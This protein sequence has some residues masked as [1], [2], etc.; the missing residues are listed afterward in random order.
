[1]AG[2]RTGIVTIPVVVHVVYNT[3]EQNISDLQIQSQINRL[4]IDF[5]RLNP[6]LNTAPQVFRSLAA[7]TRIQFQLALRDPNCNPTRGITRTHTTVTL[8]K[9]DDKVKF[10]ASGGNNAWPRDKYLNI[11]VCNLPKNLFGY[12]TYPGSS[13][14]RDGIVMNYTVF[15]DIETGTTTTDKN[16]GRTLVHEV[17][18]WLNLYHIWGPNNDSN[19]ID[20]SDTDEVDDT[21]N[22][23]GANFG[24]PEFPH[25]SC[26]NGPNGD[27]FMNHMDYTNDKCSVMFTLGQAARMEAALYGARSAILA[28]DALIPPSE[29][30]DTADLWSKDTDYDIGYEPNTFSDKMYASND[31]WVRRQKDGFTN[32]E[33]EN[34]EYRSPGSDPN[35]VYVRIRNKNCSQSGSGTVKLYWAKASTAL[36]WPAPWDGSVISPALMGGLI[37]T[38]STGSVDGGSSKILEIPWYPPNPADY[39]SFGA[40]KSHFCLL[41]RIETSSSHPYGMTFPEGSSLGENVRNNNNIVWKNVSVVEV[42]P[43]RS[44]MAQVIVGNME[45]ETSLIKVDFTSPKEKNQKSILELGTIE[46]YLGKR[47]F[48]QWEEGGSVGEG[49]KVI[50]RNTYRIQVLTANV[51]ISNIKL[52][53]NE[54]HTIEVEFIP[55]NERVEQSNVLFFDIIQYV[56]EDVD[57]FVGGQRFVFKASNKH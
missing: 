19:S 3:E 42:S 34:P 11:W 4:N 50:D 51:W 44:G 33:H 49:V 8:F 31:I 54:L 23:R 57:K 46:V 27:M 32:Q 56:K 28:S 18:H 12:A 24:C 26:D 35:Y 13:A 10:E 16:M 55:F 15:G 40:D 47:L 30:H 6:D 7:D 9:L 43:G 25:I 2:L 52:A 14:N 20:C 1:M 39:S 53:P 21:P 41:S 45:K 29:A 17:G 37:G 36:A 48:N 5:R 22:Q 38:E